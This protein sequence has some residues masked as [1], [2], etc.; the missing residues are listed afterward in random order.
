[1]KLLCACLYY[2][3]HCGGYEEGDRLGA[4]G[5]RHS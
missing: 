4:D 5:A 3:A 2:L 1:M